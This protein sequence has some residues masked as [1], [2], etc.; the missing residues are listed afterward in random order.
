MLKIFGPRKDTPCSERFRGELQGMYLGGFMHIRRSRDK[1]EA[2][3][4]MVQARNDES[5]TME[6][7]SQPWGNVSRQGEMVSVVDEGEGPLT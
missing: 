6:P 1:G 3:T 4:A 2:T 5:L 7:K